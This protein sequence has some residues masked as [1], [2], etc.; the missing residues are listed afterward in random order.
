MSEFVN[1][2]LMLAPKYLLPFKSYEHE[3][4]NIK[5]KASYRKPLLA[6]RLSSRTNIPT[7]SGQTVQHQIL[8]L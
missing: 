8:N 5:Q 1:A 7:R 6:H 4:H 2:C 3:A